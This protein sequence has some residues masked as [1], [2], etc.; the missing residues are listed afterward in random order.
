MDRPKSSVQNPS[1]RKPLG[2]SAILATVQASD[3][4]AKQY[5]DVVKEQLHH[6]KSTESD[7]V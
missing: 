1:L 6:T 4:R 5:R 7:M 3:T 2:N